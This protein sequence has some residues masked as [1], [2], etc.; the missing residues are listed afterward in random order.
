[1]IESHCNTK[2]KLRETFNGTFDILHTLSAYVDE[3]TYQ[4]KSGGYQYSNQEILETLQ[5]ECEY[6][7]ALCIEGLG[8]IAQVYTL[9]PRQHSITNGGE[10]DILGSLF[11]LLSDFL[12]TYQ[13]L[14]KRVEIECLIRYKKRGAMS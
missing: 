3:D 5:E 7:S 14:G 12:K 10:L 6:V 11:T 13:Q 8:A 4:A 9:V 2:P 1:M